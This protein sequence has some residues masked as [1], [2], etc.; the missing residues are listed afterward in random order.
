MPEVLLLLLLVL[1]LQQMLLLLQLNEA[2][3]QQLLLFIHDCFALCS[4]GS[5]VIHA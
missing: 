3:P 1:L 4:C 5:S 2:L